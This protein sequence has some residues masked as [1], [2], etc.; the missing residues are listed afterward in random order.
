MGDKNM[1]KVCP[2]LIHGD[3]AFAGQGVVYE[4]MQME[5]LPNYG[6]GGTLHVI[7]NNQVGFTTPPLKARSGVYCS[8]LAM[9]LTAPIF[10]V[11]GDSMEDVAKV[12]EIA[13][14]YR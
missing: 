4:T 7:V 10:H 14:E 9:A 5:Q 12:F 8:D 1:T 6:V 3:A 2:I 11:N 13:A